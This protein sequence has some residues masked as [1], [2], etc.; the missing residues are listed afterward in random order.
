MSSAT[1]ATALAR[2]RYICEQADHILF[3][4]VTERSSLFHLKEEYKTKTWA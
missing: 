3:V 4:G 1:N 2:N